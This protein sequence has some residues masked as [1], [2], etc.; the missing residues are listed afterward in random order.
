ML[1]A[2]QQKLSTTE[3]AEKIKEVAPEFPFQPN[4]LKKLSV[5]CPICYLENYFHITSTD[6]NSK[7]IA[8][9]H[10]CL[11]CDHREVDY[12]TETQQCSLCK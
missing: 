12:A 5:I 7:H 8:Y 2:H 11:D 4:S 9:L 3:A 10:I 1:I 6:E